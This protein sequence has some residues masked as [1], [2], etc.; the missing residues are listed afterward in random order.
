MWRS[1]VAVPAPHALVHCYFFFIRSRAWHYNAHTL[2]FKMAARKNFNDQNKL[3][4]VNYIQRII[5]FE[6]KSD[7]DPSWGKVLFEIDIIGQPRFP[8]TGII[9][10]IIYTSCHTDCKLSTPAPCSRSWWNNGSPYFTQQSLELQWT[11]TVEHIRPFAVDP[12]KTCSAIQTRIFGTQSRQTPVSF[13]LVVTPHWIW[14]LCRYTHC[15]RAP[16]FYTCNKI[17]SIQ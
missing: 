14:T 17:K 7:V 13:P 10:S 1:C 9:S 8:L 12:F 6:A 3:L 4:G 5:K 15:G 2:H 16:F 11:L